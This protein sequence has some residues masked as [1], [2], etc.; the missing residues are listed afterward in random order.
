MLQSKILLSQQN[1]AEAV[2]NKELFPY[3]INIRRN[4]TTVK[5]RHV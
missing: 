2:K 4:D 3:L 5:L 1:I